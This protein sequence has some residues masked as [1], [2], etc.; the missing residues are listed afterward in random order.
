MRRTTPA[1]ATTLA[2]LLLAGCGWGG[3]G[4]ADGEHGGRGSGGSAPPSLAKLA[5]PSGYEADHGWDEELGWVPP[6]V[7]PP[8]AVAGKSGVVAYVTQSGEG[9]AVRART[10][11]GGKVRWT[12]AAFRTPTSMAEAD[13]VIYNDDAGIPQVTTVEQDGREYVAVWAHGVVKGDAVTK[14]KE[15]V[16][17]DA[18]AADASGVSVKPLRR[19]RVPADD[20]DGGTLDIRDGGDGLLITWRNIGYHGASVDLATGTVTRYDE[21]DTLMPECD[22]GG[23]S[24]SRVVGVTSRG[25]LIGT[26][27][28]FG[29]PREW[30]GT[31]FVP[32]EA[33]KSA[34]GTVSGVRGDLFVARWPAAGDSDAFVFSAHD[35]DSGRLLASMTCGGGLEDQKKGKYDTVT[36]TNGRYVAYGTVVFDLKTGK[37]LCLEGDEDRRSV[38]I[39]HLRDDGIAYGVAA[40]VGDD[41][42]GVEVRVSG[43]APKALAAGTV[44]PHGVLDGS[45]LFV[46]GGDEGATG[47][48]LSVRQES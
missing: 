35:T 6:D 11:A 26:A 2:A 22:G 8:V 30:S 45:G 9:Y 29:V 43:G 13:E 4:K 23:C 37:G 1:V 28:G 40:V 24:Y 7:P 44:L 41:K 10:A 17:V 47:R 48:L 14:D 33:D 19:V 5:V 15:I 46:T 3:D 42:P 32:K 27:N 20:V 12:S 18:Y 39:R 38:V 25:P 36:S 34:K 21:P 31:D 16:Q